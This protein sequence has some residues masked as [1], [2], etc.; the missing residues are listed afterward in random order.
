M[1]KILKLILSCCLLMLSACEAPQ[2]IR[3]DGFAPYESSVRS[4]KAVSPER[5]MYRMRTFKNEDDAGLAFWKTALTTHMQDS[6]YIMLSESNITAKSTPGFLVVLAA[7]VGAK[8]YSYMIA[9]FVHKEKLVV[10]ESAG[11]TKYFDKYKDNIIKTI[12]NTD[13]D[14]AARL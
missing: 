9:I 2:L 5:I 14:S 11:E 1:N 12:E 4:F 3:P 10:F 8:D 7:P 6:G 13:I